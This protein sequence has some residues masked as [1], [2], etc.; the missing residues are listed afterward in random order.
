M[1]GG[2]FG[3]RAVLRALLIAAAIFGPA[4]GVF[5]MLRF[6][7]G[8]RPSDF[9]PTAWDEIENYISTATFVKAGFRG[10]YFTAVEDPAPASFTHFSTHGPTFPL[11]QGL[12][13]SVFGWQYDSAPL[14]NAACITL[15]IA[16]FVWIVRPNVLQLVLTLGT[17][18]TFYSFYEL[19]PSN[20]QEP[21]HFALG[22]AL[23]T[24]FYVAF[25]RPKKFTRRIRMG[26]FIAIL[27]AALIR[28]SWALLFVPYFLIGI[29][30]RPRYVV[31]AL[32]KAGL[33]IVISLWL[34][35]YLCAPYRNLKNAYLM[36]KVVTAETGV[37]VLLT[38]FERNLNQL[39]TPLASFGGLA[40]SSMLQTILLV[41]IFGVLAVWAFWRSRGSL[42]SIKMEAFHIY[43][44]GAIVLS[45][46]IFYFLKEGGPR[47]FPLH[48]LVTLVLLI[49][50]NR[51]IFLTLVGAMLVMNLVLLPTAL[52][53]MR[54]THSDHY[55][56]ESRNMADSFRANV[57]GKLV[58]QP[59]ADG[60]CNTVLS[61]L[62]TYNTWYAGLPPGIGI[63]LFQTEEEMANR[64]PI[65][66][67]YIL[68]D[69]PS[70]THLNA[71]AILIKNLTTPPG[72]N[73]Y[74]NANAD[75]RC[76]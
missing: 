16:F 61:G 52:A 27:V 58:Y 60:W 5:A 76:K 66:S 41:P 19:I 63:T 18:M 6:Y 67:R 75:R 49:A 14:F 72:T 20:M 29:K 17:L 71:D 22:I 7:L 37:D 31:M 69:A 59:H 12:W 33:S 25:Y 65:R 51:P 68:N 34:W 38:N 47:V 40:L 70:M 28:S 15:S 50:S 44:L 13:G 56:A 62:K 11:I 2:R 30:K 64:P 74:L 35:R 39:K 46:L 32:G 1:L 36:I 55:K 10:G 4:L 21:L 24:V 54:P 73:L 3:L 8:V 53:Q 43:N 45:T 42:R 26:L 9:T 23:G 57:D 48:L